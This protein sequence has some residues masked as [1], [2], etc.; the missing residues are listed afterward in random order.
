MTFS[1]TKFGKPLDPSLYTWDKANNVFSTEEDHLVLDFGDYN[2]VTFKTGYYCTFHTENNCTFHTGSGCIFNTGFDCTFY[3]E[4]GCIFN[5]VDNCKFYTGE[6]CI[7]NTGVN[8]TFDTENNCTFNVSWS[9]KFTV[10]KECVIVRR[11]I[12]EVIF[13]PEKKW[14]KLNDCRTPGYLNEEEILMKEIIE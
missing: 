8:C 7:F 10:G 9:C 6:N 4:D 13:P 5:T 2:G 11:D 3:T 1:V 12:F 14:I